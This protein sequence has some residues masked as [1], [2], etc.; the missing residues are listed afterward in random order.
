MCCSSLSSIEV[1]ETPLKSSTST[2]ASFLPSVH[3][4]SR[5]REDALI[6][7]SS[8]CGM[9]TVRFY[10]AEPSKRGWLVASIFTRIHPVKAC[11]PLLTSQDLY[12]HRAL[13]HVVHA[14]KLRHSTQGIGLYI[15][16][17]LTTQSY[18]TIIPKRMIGLSILT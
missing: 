5:R 12:W 18:R 6:P 10:E 4:A 2:A 3:A 11:P 15:Q 14:Y 17:K 16:Y 1:R 13:S 9:V 7:R 8:L